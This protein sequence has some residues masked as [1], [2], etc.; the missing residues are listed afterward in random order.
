MV[1]QVAAML[2]TLS[3]CL[4]VRSP[5]LADRGDRA[6]E[7]WQLCLA[8]LQVEVGAADAVVYQAG[9][10]L[11]YDCREPCGQEEIRFRS[12]RGACAADEKA[13]PVL[14]E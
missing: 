4:L 10:R 7:A 9:G 1:H 3:S 5:Q 14:N 2:G 11:A 8:L 13:Q 6:Q 12:P